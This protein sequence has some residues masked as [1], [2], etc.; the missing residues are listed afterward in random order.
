VRVP[1]SAAGDSA[2][3]DSAPE[4]SAPGDS[5]P[6]DSAPGD[7]PPGDSPA[8]GNQLG[9][10]ALF[11]PIRSGGRA[12][13]DAAAL[14]RER[15]EVAARVLARLLVTGPAA[16]AEVVAAGAVAAEVVAAGAVAAEA[17]ADEVVTEAFGRLLGAVRQGGGPSDAVRLTLLATVTG[18]ATRRAEP[19]AT[20]RHQS[21][22]WA[23]R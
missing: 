14:L 18:V 3:E 7:S 13:A 10:A 17:R 9:D 21:P 22:A 23:V 11:G 8:G 2:P 6:R 19:V 12:S 5:P 1:D 4:D 15:H 20:R 16:A